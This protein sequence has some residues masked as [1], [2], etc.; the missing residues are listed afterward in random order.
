MC[1]DVNQVQ[2]LAS[3]R[4]ITSLTAA[5][6]IQSLVEDVEKMKQQKGGIGLNVKITENELLWMFDTANLKS[7]VIAEEAVRRSFPATGELKNVSSRLITGDSLF[8]D[9]KF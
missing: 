6:D 4:S 8:V 5:K 7:R 9:S 3:S 2:F 1:I